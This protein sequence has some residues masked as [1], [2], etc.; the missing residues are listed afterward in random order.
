MK[1]FSND[2]QTK[3]LH[4]AGITR[5]PFE[6]TVDKYGSSSYIIV[7]YIIFDTK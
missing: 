2:V 5:E 1:F 3:R 4:L 7:A 6:I